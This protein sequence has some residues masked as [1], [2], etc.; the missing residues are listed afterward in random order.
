MPLSIDRLLVAE[1]RKYQLKGC[2][3]TKP[4]TLLK[5]QIPIRTFSE[6]D[7]ARSGF[8]E[9]DLV[10]HDGGRIDS[11]HAFT[12]DA[13]NVATGWVSLAAL[14]NKAQVWTRRE[15][16]N[17]RARLPFPLLGIDSDNRSEFIN[18]VLLRYCRE[19][20]IT[21]TRS[22]RPYR[23]NDGCFRSSRRKMSGC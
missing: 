14:K 9:I 16:V 23:K 10:G 3:H 11:F 5:H 15:L 2:S 22:S 12:L 19:N 8:V 4:A 13:A 18:D 17:I 6:W 1:R 21:F 7:E 20:E